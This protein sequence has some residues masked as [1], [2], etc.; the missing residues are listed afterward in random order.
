LK[1]G[2]V[3]AIIIGVVL[4]AFAFFI[5][6]IYAYFTENENFLERKE[7]NT[8]GYLPPTDSNEI[9]AVKNKNDGMFSFV[10]APEFFNIETK[11]DLDKSILSSDFPMFFSIKYYPEGF[12]PS[13]LNETYSVGDFDFLE[14]PLREESNRYNDF[15]IYDDKESVFISGYNVSLKNAENDA[16]AFSTTLGDDEYAKPLQDT[17]EKDGYEIS[18]VENQLFDE[19]Y[20]VEKEEKDGSSGSFIGIK[21]LDNDIRY[22][23]LFI[24]GEKFPS[25][26]AE[27]ASSYEKQFSR[28]VFRVSF[29]DAEELEKIINSIDVG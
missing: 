9:L 10:R 12:S 17:F 21:K 20:I 15:Y 22:Y 5:P 26:Y 16:F 13:T 28:A 2:T 3:I 25:N 24:P 29:E 1:K 11:T 27:N 4:I 18:A 14:T 6:S 8:E 19:A 23:D 7:K